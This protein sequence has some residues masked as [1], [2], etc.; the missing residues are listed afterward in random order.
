MYMVDLE[1]SSLEDGLSEMLPC[2]NF[3]Q[4]PKVSSFPLFFSEV[5]GSDSIGWVNL[6]ML[7]P[8][9]PVMMFQLFHFVLVILWVFLGLFVFCPVL[10][11]VFVLFPLLGIDC[12]D[13]SHSCLVFQSLCVHIHFSLPLPTLLHCLLSPSVFF[14]YWPAFCVTFA[15]FYYL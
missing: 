7:I 5:I 8:E 1:W 11:N 14:V 13:C 4:N 9:S 6:E 15:F 3:L 10:L 2:I 12:L